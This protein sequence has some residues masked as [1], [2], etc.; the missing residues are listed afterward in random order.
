MTHTTVEAAGTVRLEP[1]RDGRLVPYVAIVF[2]ALAAA[3]ALGEP[4]LVAAAAPFLLALAM[5]LRRTTPVDVSAKMVLSGEQVLEG[6]PIEGFVEISWSGPCD[7]HVR[8]DE[9][10]GVAADEP[11]GVDVWRGGVERVEVPLRLHAT[12]WGR[13]TVGDV[14][15]RL[16]GAHGLLTWTG[17]VLTAPVVRV[18]PGSERITRLLKPVES[19]TA[20]GVHGSRRVGEGHEFAEIRPYVAGDRLRDLN[21]AATARRG[22]PFVNRHHP[23]VSGAVLIALENYDDG[24]E[25]APIVLA[26]A[27]RAAWAL[28]SAHL[29]SND[30]VGLIGLGGS[31]Q[32][33]P[34]AGG[35]LA[36]YRLMD[37]LLRLGGEA[38]SRVSRTKRK[39]DLPPGA[40]VVALTTLQ[41]ERTLGTLLSWSATGRAVAAV[42]ID[43]MPALDAARSASEAAARRLWD[44]ELQR[45]MAVLRQ[46]GVPVASAPT[47]GALSSAIAGLRRAARGRARR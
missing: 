1:T 21:W 37:T 29:R 18:L 40:L 6:D 38:A 39:V 10:R 11:S 20:W 15:V 26:R 16:T 17:P 44:L 4:G 13:H 24:S 46:G 31:T 2:G 14:W 27:A 30:R 41:D 8:I 22:R 42:V 35:R 43:P 34:P 28:A 25:V 32:W 45:R 5:G 7:A 33:L 12:Q 23:E 9:L 47:D 19:R 3:V 36:Q